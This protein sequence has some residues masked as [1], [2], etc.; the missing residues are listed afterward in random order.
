MAWGLQWRC[1]SHS[2]GIFRTAIGC[3]ATTCGGTQV[4]LP[5]RHLYTLEELADDAAAVLDFLRIPRAIYVGLSLGGEIGQ[6][7]AVRHAD[8]IGALAL[9]DTTMRNRRSMWV[10]RIAAVEAG[11]LEP[12]VE[13][14]MQR[15]FTARFRNAH[16]EL[17]KQMRRM[18]RSTSI[19]GYL[20][21]AA[22][23]RDGQLE[24]LAAEIRQPTLI[25]AGDQ[26][27]SAPPDEPD[28]MH[29]AIA[30]SQLVLIEDAAHLPNIEQARRFN[31]V[32]G[33]FLATC[34]ASP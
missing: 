8:R 12:Q 18:V 27:G 30:G 15:W 23:M 34:A 6:M 17:V 31:A 32:L 9:C 3:S 33:D 26:D 2:P 10:E 5:P 24:R 25:V 7:L 11:G 16:P 28:V 4:R 22:A 19:K 20:G 13:P 1:G 21:C 29:R 14:A